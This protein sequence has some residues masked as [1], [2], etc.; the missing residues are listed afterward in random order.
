MFVKN[1]SLM[2]RGNS[3]IKTVPSIDTASSLW[4]KFSLLQDQ[5]MM[6]AKARVCVHSDSVLRLRKTLEPD[7]AI[8]RLE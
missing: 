8:E 2:M 6:W 7:D 3:E 1:T 5:A 4:E